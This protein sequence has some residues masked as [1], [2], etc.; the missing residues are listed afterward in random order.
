MDLQVPCAC[1]GSTRTQLPMAPPCA[2]TDP[3]QL[4]HVLGDAGES[5]DARVRNKDKNKDRYIMIYILNILILKKRKKRK[6]KKRRGMPAGLRLPVI[7]LLRL[8]FN[9]VRWFHFRYMYTICFLI[10][11]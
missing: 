11:V 3:H 5:R 8:I 1:T 9:Y 2:A 4:E 7:S 10:Y 6:K